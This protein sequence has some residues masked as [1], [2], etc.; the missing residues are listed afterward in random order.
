MVQWYKSGML[1]VKTDTRNTTFL[2]KYHFFRRVYKE[3]KKHKYGI[4]P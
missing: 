3:N 2:K 1:N 4:T